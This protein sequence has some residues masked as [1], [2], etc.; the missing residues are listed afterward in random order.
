[1]PEANSPVLVVLDSALSAPQP[2]LH[3]GGRLARAWDAPLLVAVNGC[4]PSLLRSVGP[5]DERM[6]RARLAVE[7]AWSERFDELLE[8]AALQEYAVTTRFLWEHDEMTSLRSLVIRHR[9]QL[10][11]VRSAEEHGP[12]NRL[13]L[14]PR[15]WQLLRKAPCNV[16]C[17]DDTPWPETLPV[18]AAVDTEH[19]GESLHG[20]N[21][22]IVKQAIALHD[23]LHGGLKLCH[24]V[25]R[26]EETLIMV[27]GEA[28]PSYLRDAETQ[29]EYYQGKLE[30]LCEQAG[31]HGDQAL[32]LEGVPA[33]A[34]SEYQR[35]QGPLLLV[36]GTV[37]RSAMGRLLLGSTAEEIVS[38]AGGD[39]LAVKEPD[40]HSPWE[41]PDY[42]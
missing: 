34:L 20:L 24:V 36:L 3:K 42:E 14:T 12:L 9:P 10:V 39:L 33:V 18:L 1:M 5:D 2:A 31:L 16:L 35:Q 28:I 6:A 38:R 29:R 4:S 19:D 23:V 25:E 15:D 11:V 22:A 37:S 27:A 41:K 21:A 30:A 8:E 32:V 17:V 40:F 13:F 7:H 26:P